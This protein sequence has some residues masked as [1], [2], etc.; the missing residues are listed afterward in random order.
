MKHFTFQPGFNPDIK[1]RFRSLVAQVVQQPGTARLQTGEDA[2][3]GIPHRN[4]G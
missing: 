3:A 2:A 1:P 4:R